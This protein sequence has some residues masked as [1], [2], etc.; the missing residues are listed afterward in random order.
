MLDPEPREAFKAMCEA[1]ERGWTYYT[2]GSKKDQREKRKRRETFSIGWLKP[3]QATSN[4]DFNFLCKKATVSNVEETQEL[5]FDRHSRGGTGLTANTLASM[6]Y[7]AKSRVS[8]QNALRWLYVSSHPSCSKIGWLV[9]N[10]MQYG[11]KEVLDE[12]VKKGMQQFYKKWAFIP[13]KTGFE[14]MRSSSYL[15]PPLV[16]NQFNAI[17]N[18]GPGLFRDGKLVQGDSGG[19]WTL[20]F[21][22]VG[23]RGNGIDTAVKVSK[24]IFDVEDGLK[25]VN[26]TCRIFECCGYGRMSV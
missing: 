21:Q 14:T 15:I 4:T 10:V 23:G 22:H 3:L 19:S 20:Q 18:G 7:K 24:S 8:I 5:F 12:L 16:V 2:E 17:K 13:S 26:R 25:I 11:E 6:A 9:Q 1:Y